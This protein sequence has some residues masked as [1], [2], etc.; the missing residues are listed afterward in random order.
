MTFTLIK[1]YTSQGEENAVICN[2][3]IYWVVDSIDLKNLTILHGEAV[4]AHLIF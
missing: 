3:R 1:T 4:L 2:T